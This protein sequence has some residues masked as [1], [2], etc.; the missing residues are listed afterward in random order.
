MLFI[1]EHTG[2]SKPSYSVPPPEL[3]EHDLQ[4]LHNER[5]PHGEVLAL[6]PESFAGIVADGD[7][8]VKFF[9]PWW[10]L[11]LLG[12]F[13]VDVDEDT[14]SDRCGHCKKLA[15][16]WEKLAKGLQHRVAVAEVNCED[17]KSLC[18]SEGVTGFPMLFFYPASG[19]KTEYSGSR[20]VEAMKDWAERAVRP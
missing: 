14:Y 7:V 6:T 8:F 2:V 18:S 9:A 5:N 20:R 11:H 16:I 15:P 4:T 19:K 10:V 1:E 17:Y 12:V 3:P 13:Q